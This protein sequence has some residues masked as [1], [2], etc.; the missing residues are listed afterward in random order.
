MGPRFS[1]QEPPH[2]N[3]VE[4]YNTTTTKIFTTYDCVSSVKITNEEAGRGEGREKKTR[5]KRRPGSPVEGLLVLF[6]LATGQL[7]E[8]CVNVYEFVLLF[9]FLPFLELLVD[10]LPPAK[11]ITELSVCRHPDR[12]H[13]FA[14][15]ISV[16]VNPR[17]F[18]LRSRDV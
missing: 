8:L 9:H 14:T 11:Q 7:V 2:S 4:R 12:F 6:D 18:D 15:R 5:K 3:S 17:D 10:P 16:A 1:F 13:F